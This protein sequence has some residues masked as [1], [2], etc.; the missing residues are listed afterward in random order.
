MKNFPSGKTHLAEVVQGADSPSAVLLDTHDLVQTHNMRRAPGFEGTCR[1][2]HPETTTHEYVTVNKP[3]QH[4]RI[5]QY[6]SQ[7][8]V[9]E[10]VGCSITSQAECTSVIRNGK[11]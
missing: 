10:L 11:A 1:L 4:S 2:L 6:P 9:G 5:L 8:G 3:S 7:F